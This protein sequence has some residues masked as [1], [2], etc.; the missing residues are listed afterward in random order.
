[1]KALELKHLAPYANTGVQY[2]SRE[3][4]YIPFTYEDLYD[5]EI[6]QDEGREDV[7]VDFYKL[8]LR[9][10]SDLTKEIEHKGEKFVP[11]DYLAKELGIPNDHF[12][13]SQYC[14]KAHS[15]RSMSYWMV[16]FLL[17]WHFDIWNLIEAGL[18][19]DINTLEK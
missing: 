9:P 8:I 11:L 12:V 10:L 13:L 7:V 14:S 18:A 19:V 17:E 15:V 2:L 6:M 4:S 5:I 16:E 1:M 3:G